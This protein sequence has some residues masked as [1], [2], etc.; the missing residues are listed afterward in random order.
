MPTKKTRNVCI[1]F[2]LL[3]ICVFFTACGMRGSQ[4]A[5]DAPTI[6]I[7][8]FTGFE[9]REDA[10]EWVHEGT[11]VPYKQ[12]IYWAAE[13]THG[14]I[15]GYAYRVLNAE[16]QPIPTPGHDFIDSGYG[17]TPEVLLKYGDGWVMHYVKGSNDTTP[18]SDPNARRTIWTE[19]VK[20]VI[21]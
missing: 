2:C 16:G 15:K 19:D 17:V 7:T 18:L 13:S 8:S 20:T 21:N 4:F 11:T 9:S 10:E 5:T 1:A 3:V 12:E 6:K 14:V